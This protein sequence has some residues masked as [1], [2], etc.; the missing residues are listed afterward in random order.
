M[1][2]S[3]L[4]CSILGAFMLVTM[5]AAAA[6]PVA[7][8]LYND[9]RAAAQA[10]DWNRACAL[11]QE[12]QNREPA[13]G[14]LLNLADCEEHRARLVT[15]KAQFQT[16]ARLFEA[17][18]SRVAYAKQRAA[19]LEKRVARLRVRLEGEA[20]VVCDGAVVDAAGFGNFVEMDPGEHLFVV[21]A[22]GHAEMR[23]MV[24]LG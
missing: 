15:A 10:K 11:Y 21:K 8:R 13:P 23:R 16:A 5:P 2:F 20:T 17:S 6:D 1:R 9:G 4:S 14:T 18:D 3:T 19:A 24:R 22:P 7:E 12:S